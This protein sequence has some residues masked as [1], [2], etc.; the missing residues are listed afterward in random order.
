MCLAVSAGVIGFLMAIFIPIFGT[1]AMADIFGF[2][3]PLSFNVLIIL[4]FTF[5]ALR[6]FLRYGEQ[7]CNHFIAFTVLA[8]LRDKIFSALRRLAPA[9][10]ENRDKG[11]LISMVTADVEIMEVFYAH[12]VSPMII[13]GIV[14]VVMVLFIGSFHWIF[15]LIALSTY[16][17]VGVFLPL[18]ISKVGRKS[19]I[20]Q[21][22]SFSKLND[23]MYETLKGISEI[24]QFGVEKQRVDTISKIGSDLKKNQRKLKKYGFQTSLINGFAMVFF[25][26]LIL[27][28]GGKLYQ[29]DQIDF[30][31]MIIPVIALLSSF[32]PVLALSNVANTLLLVSASGKRIIDLINEQPEVNEITNGSDI[33]FNKLECDNIS[34]SYQKE[35]ILNGLSLNLEQNKILSINGKSGSGKSTLLKLMMRFWE[36]DSGTIKISNEN[37]NHINTSSLRINQSYLT[38]NP[39]L[40]DDTIAE[41]IRIGNYNADL[42]DIKNAAKKASVD[43]FINKLENGYDTR[44]GELGDRLSAGEKQRISLA[45]LFLHDAPLLLLDEPTS[46]IDSLN[47]GIIL[48]SLKDASADKTIILVTHRTST[49]GIAEEYLNMSE[50]RKS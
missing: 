23:Y 10:L 37:I 49:K 12:T 42:E 39:I 22:E 14:S 9:K 33:I 47:E 28:F 17:F 44:V 6:G 36:T 38:Q 21:R 16:L 30:P 5:A 27:I 50:I 3:V 41:N 20:M 46:N 25:P 43:E 40:L 2:K 32:G 18:Y 7:L 26:A 15:G 24:F 19:G 34:F 1:Y 11:S 45:R 48:K 13:G 29:T 31:S 4:C 8:I 35:N